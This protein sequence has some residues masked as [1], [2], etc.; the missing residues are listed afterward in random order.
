[1]VTVKKK[2]LGIFLIGIGAFCAAVLYMAR[3]Y[4]FSFSVNS[5]NMYFMLAAEDMLRGNWLLKGWSGGFFTGLTTDLLWVAALRTVLSRKAVLYLI[6]PLSHVL[7]VSVS[8]FLL[9][10]KNRQRGISGIFFLA[11]IFS[12]Q[13]RCVIQC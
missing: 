7:I 6:G 8:A 10:R 3:F 11:A 13:L 2:H 12:C 5:D 4:A 9:W 1:M